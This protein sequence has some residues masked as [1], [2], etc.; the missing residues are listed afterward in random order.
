M[1]TKHRWLSVTPA[2]TGA[3]AAA[4]FAAAAACSGTLDPVAPVSPEAPVASP[5]SIPASTPVTN[6]MGDPVEGSGQRAGTSALTTTQLELP[7]LQDLDEQGFDLLVQLTEKHSPRTS[8]TEKERA[9]ALYISGLFSDLG[10]STGLRPFT[11]DL[12]RTDPPVL[13]VHSENPPTGRAFPLTL[14]GQGAAS[15]VLTNVGG[16]S[17]NDIEAGSLEGR[18][19]LIE[20]GVNTFEDKVARATEAGVVAA[21]IFNNRSGSF[22]GRLTTRSGIPA[23]SVSREMGEALLALMET[24]EVVV[25]I[26]VVI[27]ARDSANIVA[28]LPGSDPKAGVVVLGGHYDTVAGVDGANDN[29]SGIAALLTLARHAAE[30]SYP[31]TLRVI[32]FGTEEEGLHGSRNFVDALSADETRD[33]IAMLNFD[34]LGSGDTAAMIATAWLGELVLELGDDLG[35]PIRLDPS[36]GLDGGSSDFAPFEAAG[37]PFVFFFADDFSRIHTA[38]DMLEHIDPLRIGEAAAL[39]LATLDA[40]AAGR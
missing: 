28:D 16:A 17:A 12:V 37:V 9:A 13:Q 26:S 15:G 4:L 33:I 39:G 27:E 5:T 18:V 19:A 21:V 20:R 29:G 36:L 14:S 1:T 3:L 31:F 7:S 40:L 30:R 24:G 2:V 35:V 10:Y 11:V 6:E 25:T 22:S 32:A 38:E 8:A 23:V 34:A